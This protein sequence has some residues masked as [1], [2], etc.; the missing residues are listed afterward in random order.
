MRIIRSAVLLLAAIAAIL[1]GCQVQPPGGKGIPIRVQVAG[2]RGLFLEGG[3]AKPLHTGSRELVSATG[4]TLMAITSSNQPQEATFTDSTGATV[5][6]TINRALQVNSGYMLIDYTAP[7]S[8]AVAIVD[9]GSGALVAIATAPDNWVNIYAIAST[10]FYEA[11]GNIVAVTLATGA[12]RTLSSGVPVYASVQPEL[13]GAGNQSN[14]LQQPFTFWNQG[15]W[16]YADSAG[17]GYAL[18]VQSNQF[19]QAAAF[20][21]DGS[22]QVDFGSNALAYFFAT[23]LPV[24]TA[25][26]SN[27]WAAIDS[28]TGAVYVILGRDEWDHDPTRWGGFEITGS[29]VRIYRVAM[30]PSTP[31]VMDFDPLAPAAALRLDSMYGSGT[32]HVG[33]DF[34]IQDSVYSNGPETLVIAPSGGSVA[35]SHYDTSGIP[36]ES[37]GT[38][39]VMN[40]RFSRGTLYAGPTLGTSTISR[41]DLPAGGGVASDSV[42]IDA[43]GIK[44]WAVSGDQVFYSTMEA[45]Y[46][47]DPTSEQT[48]LYSADPVSIQSIE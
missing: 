10:M 43:A 22:P 25:G 17:N 34:A 36:V 15:T 1:L 44:D 8:S 7:D 20:P 19:F 39:A 12:E 9:L 2:A 33:P 24:T 3:D 45:T 6:V 30:D 48:T 27:Q 16:I 41:V 35:I 5:D 37:P 21:A 42:L 47:Y 26:A 4:A 28:T 31:A 40:W 38:G 32:T 14:V 13:S 11:E 46:Q 23:W 29:A 18:F